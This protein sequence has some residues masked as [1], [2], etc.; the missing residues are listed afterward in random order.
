MPEIHKHCVR[1]IHR[2]C[3]YA[4]WMYLVHK[5]LQCHNYFHFKTLIKEIFGISNCF[6]AWQLFNLQV[7]LQLFCSIFDLLNLS[8]LSAL[9]GTMKEWGTGVCAYI[10]KRERVVEAECYTNV[11]RIN[12][13]GKHFISFVLTS[14]LIQTSE[15]L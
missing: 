8:F 15:R 3:F 13:K 12:T 9:N 7:T 14:V 1:S 6:T 5:W 2:I 4:F 11:Y 10:Y